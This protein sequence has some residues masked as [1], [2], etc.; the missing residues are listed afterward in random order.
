MRGRSRKFHYY[1]DNPEALRSF[2]RAGGRSGDLDFDTIRRNREKR[3]CDI[4]NPNR[5]DSGR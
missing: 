1:L 5:D 4:N 3:Y 2:D